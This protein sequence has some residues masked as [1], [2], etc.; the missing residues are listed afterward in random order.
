MGT[1]DV[2]ANVIERISQLNVHDKHEKRFTTKLTISLQMLGFL[3]LCEER[4]TCNEEVYIIAIILLD[5]L[6]NRENVMIIHSNKFNIFGTAL[7][8][9]AKT[10]M[11][12]HHTNAQFADV[13]H[14]ELFQLNYFERKF[15]NLIKFDVHVTTNVYNMYKTHI[16]NYAQ[17]ISSNKKS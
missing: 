17:K 7:M 5:R 12:D 16:T 14:L 8:V 13:F 11:D 1:L 15:C 4:I 6:R 9:A 2:I 3:K 10:H